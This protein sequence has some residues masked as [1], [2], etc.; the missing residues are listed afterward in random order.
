MRTVIAGSVALLTLWLIDGLAFNGKYT[1]AGR[2]VL[3]KTVSAI[4]R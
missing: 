2:V 1:M 4:L 3:T